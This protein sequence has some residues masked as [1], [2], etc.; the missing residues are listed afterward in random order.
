MSRISSLFAASALAA[1]VSSFAVSASADPPRPPVMAPRIIRPIAP[2]VAP[3]V[4]PAPAAKAAAPA[5]HAAATPGGDGAASAPRVVFAVKPQNSDP[6]LKINVEG[7]G[8]RVLIK[9][10]A[11]GPEV[12]YS[13]DIAFVGGKRERLVNYEVS[14]GIS[15]TVDH[16][17]MPD[18]SKDAD[19]SRK[20]K[21]YF[22]HLASVDTKKGDSAVTVAQRLAD[23]LNEGGAFEAKVVE[24]PEGAAI[25]L[26]RVER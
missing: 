12:H 13:D 22:A 7:G 5:T 20:N 3:R 14:R 11:E 19:Y 8:A 23:K 18:F 26:T 17:K 2:R 24:A 1:M 4:A 6:G 15:F 9:G 16:D 21:W 10:V 25:E